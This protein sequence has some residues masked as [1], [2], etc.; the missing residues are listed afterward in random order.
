[1][2]V[3]QTMDRVLIVSP[4]FPPS[5][6]AGVHRARHLA[7][8]LPAHGW[9]PTILSVDPRHHCER[10]DPDLAALV[11]HSVDAVRVGAVSPA[12]TRPLGIVG[13]IGLRGFVHLRAGIARYMARHSAHAVLITGS[14]YW[15]MLLASWIRQRWR[16]PV[17]LDFQ[18]PWVS[19]DGPEHPV[20]SKR[21]LAHGL[22]LAL[23]P[24]AL[25]SADYVTSV[26]ERQNDELAARHPWLDRTRMQ[27]IPIGGDPDDFK[28]LAARPQNRTS[29]NRPFVISYVG[30]ALPRARPLLEALFLGLAGLRRTAPGLAS[31]IQLRFVGTSNSSNPDAHQQI[32][33]LAEAA[34]VGDQVSE[35]AARVP[36]LDAL[37]ILATTDAILMVGSDEPHYTASKIYPALM[38]G[39]PFLS[40]FHRESSA[41][42]LLS[43]A[44]GGIAV[45]FD[46]SADPGQPADR[47]ASALLALVRDPTALGRPCPGAYAAYTA[48]SVAGR[49]ADVFSRVQARPGAG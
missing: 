48:H 2:T 25:R 38:A 16:V 19:R 45:P 12:L 30:T 7:K 3:G 17:V 40:L 41:H 37:R 6:V 22:S 23:E 10:L 31:R 36:Y 35:A 4:Y 49:F 1:V 27:A 15:P 34:G 33:P 9:A 46:P 11:P 28:A 5:M 14:P 44:G 42:R 20:W 39:P 32:M 8:H 24:L 43:D 29:E 26:S 18:D 47:M 21:R 13:D